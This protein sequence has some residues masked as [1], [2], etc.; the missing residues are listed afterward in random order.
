MMPP[1]PQTGL[2]NDVIAEIILRLPPDE[3]E[4][5]FRATLVCKP[6]HRVLCDPAFPPQLPRLPPGAAPARPPLRARGH[7]RGPRARPRPHH[8]GTPLPHPYYRRPLDCRHGRVLLH[9]DDGSW[10]LIVWDPMT[11]DVQRLPEPDIL[12][13]IYTA[14]CKQTGRLC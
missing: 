5:L 2:I 13:L 12:W 14:A 6:W 10:Y 3:P 4:H 8:D 1:P 7:A 11:G 9:S